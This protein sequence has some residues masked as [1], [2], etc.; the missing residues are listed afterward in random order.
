[1]G[2]HRPDRSL[3]GVQR[4]GFFDAFRTAG[5]GD[6]GAASCSA[7]GASGDGSKINE[8]A[9]AGSGAFTT[10]GAKGYGAAGCS[11]AACASGDGFKA[12]ES[13]TAGIEVFRTAGAKSFGA[14]D[15]ATGQGADSAGVHEQV[16]AILGRR[17]V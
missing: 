15:S 16:A 2:R 10:A 7:A 3:P 11:A 12:D 1:M 9:A 13:A 8:S 17:P 6:F 5:A 14:A 4:V